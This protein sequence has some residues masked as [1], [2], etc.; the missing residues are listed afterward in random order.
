[1]EQRHDSR[2]RLW[3]VTLR[4]CN[5]HTH[6]LLN[7]L[8]RF[9]FPIKLDIS[10]YCKKKGFYLLRWT[11]R[12]LWPSVTVSMAN[13]D[14]DQ[15]PL[16]FYVQ[17]LRIITPSC[18]HYTSALNG[19]RTGCVRILDSLSEKSFTPYTFCQKTWL[20]SM[21]WLGVVQWPRIRLDSWN[22][23]SNIQGHCGQMKDEE[24]SYMHHRWPRFVHTYATMMYTLKKSDMY[25]WHWDSRGHTVVTGCCVQLPGHITTCWIRCPLWSTD[26]TEDKITWNP[27]A[28][29]PFCTVVKKE[30]E[31]VHFFHL[32]W[33][34]TQKPHLE[35][36][37]TL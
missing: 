18:W 5:W 29:D 27:S 12:C 35:N 37:H 9:T 1:M 34:L 17:W 26:E 21:A 6:E 13:K 24:T 2:R 19:R 32:V 20:M 11:S 16:V 14:L 25:F 15:T 23:S 36:R 4:F 28:G 31:L 7:E 10:T 3:R 33:K 8:S 22:L 30:K